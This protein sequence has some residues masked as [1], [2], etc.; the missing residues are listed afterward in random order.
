MNKWRRVAAA[1]IALTLFTSAN[2]LVVYAKDGYLNRTIDDNRQ[3]IQILMKNKSDFYQGLYT[4][5]Y[6]HRSVLISA[7]KEL[8]QNCRT[9]A[10]KADA[11]YHWITTNLYYDWDGVN[12]ETLPPASPYE[13]YTGKLAVCEGFATLFAEMMNAVGVP[14]VAFHGAANTDPLG[15]FKD[16][17]SSWTK[18]EYDQVDHAWNA[19]YVGGQWLYYD[20]TWDC[21]NKKTGGKLI[22]GEAGK[23]YFGLTPEQ[24]ASNHRTAYRILDEGI[25]KYVDGTWK[26]CDPNG[27]LFTGV[28]YDKYN[29]H[30]YYMDHGIP[31]TG[32]AIV[33]YQLTE[34]N[35]KGQYVR[36][37]YEYTGW[38]KYQNNWYY[39]DKGITC[40]GWGKFDGTWYYLDPD[41]SIM[42]TGWQKIDGSWYYF[43]NQNG[44]MQTDWQKIDN[45]W[46]YFQSWGGMTTGWRKVQGKWYYFR[47][48]GGMATGWL[49][50]GDKWYY[51]NE[52]GDMATGWRKV[53]GK[54][55]YFLSD[56]SM[57]V[58]QT[59]DGYW[60]N[61]NGTY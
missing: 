52:A 22:K 57:A 18:E 54:W 3:Q 53:Q 56:G 58:N 5:D 1:A 23:H 26:L 51:L 61:E 36:T 30:L 2:S 25:F 14:C 13:V 44:A 39:I 6:V 42:Q 10:Q 12:S 40:Y 28:W 27:N 9:D 32:L 37:L 41:T 55:Y 31:I 50:L 38:Q 49:K 46:Y 17:V 29:S 15:V 8:T 21:G 11:I 47:S 24:F 4:P 48:W 19:A 45:N 20:P 34:F 7:A 59:V 35:S 60:L 33:D 43:S 16:S